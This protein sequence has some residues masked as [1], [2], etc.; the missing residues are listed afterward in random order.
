MRT[1]AKFLLAVALGIVV[2]TVA[3]EWHALRGLLHYLWG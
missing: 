2:A 3:S 1:A